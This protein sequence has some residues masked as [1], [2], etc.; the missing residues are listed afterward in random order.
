MRTN[1]KHIPIPQEPVTKTDLLNN[2]I[3]D[4]DKSINALNELIAKVKGTVADKSK[5][6]YKFTS[7]ASSLT[8]APN[9]ISGQ[10]A[11]IKEAVNQLNELLF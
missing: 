6:K 5:A 3:N 8:D 10:T 9:V 2:A 11:T 1:K 7:L 4:L